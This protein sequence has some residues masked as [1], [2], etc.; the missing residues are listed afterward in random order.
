MAPLRCTDAFGTEPPYDGGLIA[1]MM[2]RLQCAICS[3]LRTRHTQ[4]RPSARAHAG[5]KRSRVDEVLML[6]GG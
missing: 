5:P 1:L 6:A 3:K 4:K 2:L